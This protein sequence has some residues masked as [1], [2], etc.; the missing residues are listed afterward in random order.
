MTDLEAVKRNGF[1]LKYIKNQTPE[2]CLTAVKENGWALEFVKEQT[3]EI[4]IEAV[5]KD[6]AAVMYVNKK[7]DFLF[8]K[9][10]KKMN[11]KEIRAEVPELF[12]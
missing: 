11:L 1:S 8:Q 12:L 9:K 10:F 4:C 5:K 6:K 3:P 7:F 2:I